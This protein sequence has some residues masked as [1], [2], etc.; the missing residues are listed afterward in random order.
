MRTPALSQHVASRCSPSSR[1][2]AAEGSRVLLVSLLD[3]TIGGIDQDTGRRLWL[4]DTGQPLVSN[5]GVAGQDDQDMATIFPGADGSLY[6]YRHSAQTFEVCPSR[7]TS[8]WVC[9]KFAKDWYWRVHP[10]VRQAF[11]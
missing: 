6:A 11:L 10:I 5:K 7:G 9:F 3:G 4:H 8:G 2:D 1:S